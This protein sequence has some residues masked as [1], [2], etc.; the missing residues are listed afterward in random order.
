VATDLPHAPSSEVISLEEEVRCVSELVEN[1][2]LQVNQVPCTNRSCHA[3]LAVLMRTTFL[4][5][6]ILGASRY[7]S[8]GSLRFAKWRV[9]KKVTYGWLTIRRLSAQLSENRAAIAT[10]QNPSKSLIVS[11][12]G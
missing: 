2:V 12:Y 8:P 5:R 9:V 11:K 3:D 4:Q 1:D 7:T 10:R 6:R